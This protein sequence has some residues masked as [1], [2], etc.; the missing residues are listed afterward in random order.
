MTPEPDAAGERAA[1]Q[2]RVDELLRDLV[3]RFDAFDPD[4]CE[5]E[6]SEG[7]IKLLFADGSRCVLN[8]QSAAN[9]VWLA[10]GTTAWH[11]EFDAA[12]GAWRDT[13]GRG[14]LRAILG[15]MLTRRLGRPVALEG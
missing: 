14:E 10:E 3:Q 2:R 7:V 1:F 13:K 11:F 9:Q 6:T 12:A 15:Q 5:A 8:R 4:E